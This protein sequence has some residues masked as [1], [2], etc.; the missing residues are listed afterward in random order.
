MYFA[1][2]CL[3]QPSV[4]IF[5]FE[6]QIH[7]LHLQ[8][9]HSVI[10]FLHFLYIRNQNQTYKDNSYSKHK[11]QENLKYLYILISYFG[12]PHT[13]DMCDTVHHRDYSVAA[14]QLGDWKVLAT[15]SALLGML[16]AHS[17]SML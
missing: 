4:Y 2:F 12:A 6:I 9:C 11:N 15:C 17:E 3:V 5:H 14:L 8:C 10:V 1:N 13:C 7:V 16:C